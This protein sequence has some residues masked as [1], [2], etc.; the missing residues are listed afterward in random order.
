MDFLYVCISKDR[1][2]VDPAKIAG[3]REWP[4]N[5]QNVKGARSFIGVVGYHHIFVP[6][7]SEIAA[8]IMKLF[9]K[10]VPFEWGPPQTD[11]MEKLITAVTN[12]PVLVRLDPSRQ[13]EL[14][15]DASQI[16]TGGILYQRDPVVTMPN[17]KE[18]PGP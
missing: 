17:R 15:V 2:T 16:A 8:P 10:N 6:H 3:I 5:I 18:K 7:F 11:A 4:R 12:A 9:S 14:E 13:F 1:V